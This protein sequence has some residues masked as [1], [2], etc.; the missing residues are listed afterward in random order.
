[1]AIRAI[2]VEAVAVTTI[3]TVLA[4]KVILTMAI[5]LETQLLGSSCFV[6]IAS[7]QVTLFKSVINYMDIH[8]VID[9]LE[10]KGWQPLLLKN[11]KG[12]AHIEFRTVSAA[13]GFAQQ[14]TS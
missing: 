11:K 14:T 13:Y 7:L 8:R 5:L 3:L 1:M 6:I 10:A 9:Y 12:F 4:M 2:L